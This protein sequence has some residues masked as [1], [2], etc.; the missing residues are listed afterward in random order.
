MISI[1]YC[2]VILPSVKIVVGIV[3]DVSFLMDYIC[4]TS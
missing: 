3:S 1:A 4:N 2:H